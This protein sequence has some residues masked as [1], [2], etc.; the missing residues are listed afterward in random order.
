MHPLHDVH[1]MNAYGAGRVSMSVHMFQLD[2]RWTDVMTFDMES[3]PLEATL[4]LVFFFF[5][6]SYNP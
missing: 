2:S 1:E 5:L 4:K 6:I 3:M